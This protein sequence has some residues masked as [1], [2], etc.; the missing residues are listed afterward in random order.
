V[1]RKRT[2]EKADGVGLTSG[3]CAILARL[4]SA[5]GLAPARTHETLSGQRLSSAWPIASFRGFQGGCWD[6]CWDA[7]A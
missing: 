4:R 5:S 1:R 2:A 3:R 7:V 6:E